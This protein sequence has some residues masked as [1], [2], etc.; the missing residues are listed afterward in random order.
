ML[1][2]QH[3]VG[4]IMPAPTVAARLTT[5]YQTSGYALSFSIL[6]A[7]DVSLGVMTEPGCYPFKIRAFCCS[8]SASVKM[9]AF[10]SSPS[11]VSWPSRSLISGG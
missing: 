11:C 4:S 2:N 8:N 10:S 6:T 5:A 7:T 3:Q 1:A 9:P